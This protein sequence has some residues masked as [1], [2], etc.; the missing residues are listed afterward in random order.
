MGPN[1]YQQLTRF[2]NLKQF[3]VCKEDECVATFRG[4]NFTALH[5]YTPIANKE[6]KKEVLYFLR[7]RDV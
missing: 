5:I 1:E 7:G 3:G 2:L 4:G 6:V